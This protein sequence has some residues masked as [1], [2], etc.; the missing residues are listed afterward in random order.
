MDVSAERAAIEGAFAGLRFVRNQMGY[1]VDLADFIQP[2]QHHRGASEAP[3]QTIEVG[4]SA[5]V[6]VRVGSSSQP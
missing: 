5:G 6:I 2:E 1:H 4:C 3:P